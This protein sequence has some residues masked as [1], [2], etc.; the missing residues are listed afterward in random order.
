MYNGKRGF[1]KGQWKYLFYLFYPLH[2]TILVLIRYY[3]F[4]I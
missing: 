1:I 4:H 2:I 3:M